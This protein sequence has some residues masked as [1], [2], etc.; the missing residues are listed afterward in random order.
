MKKKHPKQ[1]LA[2]S[3]HLEPILYTVQQQQQQIAHE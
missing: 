1:H 3:C 2:R